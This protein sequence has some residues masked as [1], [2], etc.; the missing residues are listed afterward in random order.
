VR[1]TARVTFLEAENRYLR[2]R[3]AGITPT[4]VLAPP[5]STADHLEAVRLADRLR[6]AEDHITHIERSYFWRARRV[7]VALNALVGRRR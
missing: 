5:D 1:L 4:V 2:D 7:W 6:R 3:A